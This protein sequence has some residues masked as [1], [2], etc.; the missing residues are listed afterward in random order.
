MALVWALVVLTTTTELIIDS[1]GVLI[2][3]IQDTCTF[4]KFLCVYKNQT[5]NT[6][7]G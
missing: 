1:K 4:G 5:S 3:K 2:W 7:I 6:S